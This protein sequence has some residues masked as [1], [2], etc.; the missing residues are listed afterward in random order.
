MEIPA[1]VF[2]GSGTNIQLANLSQRSNRSVPLVVYQI[3]PR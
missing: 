2:A 3:D 1:P